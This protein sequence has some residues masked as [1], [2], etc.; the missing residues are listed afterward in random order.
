VWRDPKTGL[1]FLPAVLRKPLFHSSEILS[2]ETTRTLF[3]QLRA[4]YDYVIVDLPPLTPLVDVR[5]TSS[6]VDFFILVVEWGRTKI[7]VAQHALHTAPNVYENLIGVVL[8]K[9]DI[10][11][12]VRYDAEHSDYYSDSHYTRYGLS[13]SS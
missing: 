6:L 9:T 3:D 1:V 5:V 7:G 8:N 10:K 12:M 4:A 11:S 13:D 2:A